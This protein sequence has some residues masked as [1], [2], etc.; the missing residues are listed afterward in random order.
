MRLRHLANRL[1]APCR[2]SLEAAVGLCVSRSHWAIE[3]AHWWL[4]L[5]ETPDI[6]VFHLCKTFEI[7]R[8]RA[9]RHL[10]RVLDGLKADTHRQPSLGPKTLQLLTESW[11]VASLDCQVGRIRTGH[12]LLASLQ[13][14]TVRNDV[15]AFSPELAS[16]PAPTVLERFEDSVRASI[17]RNELV[18]PPAPGGA[19]FRIFLCYRR[20]D[21]A[22]AGRVYDSLRS[23][24]GVEQVFQD[25]VGIAPGADWQ[26][27][28]DQQLDACA[29]VV[30]VIGKYWLSPAGI[31][32][33]QDPD[34]Y[35]RYEL[36]RAFGRD[37]HVVPLLEGDTAMPTP[38]QLPENIRQLSRRHAIHVGGANFHDSLARVTTE[39]KRLA[40]ARR[41]PAGAG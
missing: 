37:L 41:H 36:G 20:E 30:L 11:L 27:T 5:L 9:V 17:E 23:E 32:R 35:V 18:E 4:K 40:A 15:A 22:L 2:H 8:A 19:A 3:P 28:I 39:L 13:E 31:G 33:L 38:E 29:A 12:V 10:H 25:L 26:T 21:W 24:F 34:D 7:D 16:L 1:N 6:D 14:P